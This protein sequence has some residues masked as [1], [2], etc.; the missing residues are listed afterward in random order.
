MGVKEKAFW[1]ECKYE[2]KGLNVVNENIPILIKEYSLEAIKNAVQPYL[3]AENS[4]TFRD[5]SCNICYVN[6]K[7][8]PDYLVHT[9]FNSA[10][11]V[12]SVRDKAS[13]SGGHGCK[14]QMDDDVIAVFVSSHNPPVV[15]HAVYVP[16]YK[17]YD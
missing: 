12:A 14:V 3:K 13:V 6:T 9:F 2:I 4:F 7:D 16:D 1:L 5:A 8:Y 10:N 15:M 11:I 17:G